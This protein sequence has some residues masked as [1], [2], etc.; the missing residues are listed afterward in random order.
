MVSSIPC[1]IVKAALNFFLKND[2]TGSGKQLEKC[3]MIED[4][5]GVFPV[6]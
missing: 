5:N 2:A 6:R 3:S 1:V 4:E